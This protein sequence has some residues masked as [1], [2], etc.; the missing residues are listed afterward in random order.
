MPLSS[1]QS[2][3]LGIGAGAAA[4]PEAA[5]GSAAG[6]PP[7]RYTRGSLAKLS[8][9]PEVEALPESTSQRLPGVLLRAARVVETTSEKCPQAAPRDH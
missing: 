7:P 5:E 6:A 2:S 9:A 4:E 1:L 8:P 3:L